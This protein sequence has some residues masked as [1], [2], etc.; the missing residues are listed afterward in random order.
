MA[1]AK[2]KSSGKSSSA[3][4]FKRTRQDHADETAEDYVELVGDLTAEKGEARLV[5]LARAL[6]I[7]HV[8]ASKTIARLK[9]EGLVESRPYRAIFLTDKGT[10][11]ARA[12]R[13]RHQLVLEFLVAIGVAPKQAAVD[14]EGIEHHV[15]SATLDAM[16]RLISRSEKKRTPKRAAGKVRRRA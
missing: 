3:N 5:D 9:K 14:A 15:S 11:L 13:R 10:E 1:K 16:K 8:T 7:T 4:T 2:R 12:A 6:G